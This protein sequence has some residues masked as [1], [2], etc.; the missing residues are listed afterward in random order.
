MNKLIKEM[1][2]AKLEEE[3]GAGMVKVYANGSVFS[4][5]INLGSL[6]DFAKEFAASAEQKNAQ[7]TMNT[8]YG[9]YD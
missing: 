5:G 2:I 4:N 6:A 1:V 9:L 8:G 3:H 7:Q